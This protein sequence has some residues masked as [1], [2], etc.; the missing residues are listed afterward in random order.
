MLTFN[1]VFFIW[2]IITC[3]LMGV[4]KNRAKNKRWRISETRLLA[5]AFL[6]G[7]LGVFTGMHVFHHKTKHPKFTIG[8]PLLFLING[9]MYYVLWTFLH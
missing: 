4:D 7:A 3:L 2:N 1:I 6:G 9:I 8:V 5:V